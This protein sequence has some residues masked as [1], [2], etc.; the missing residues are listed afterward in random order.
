MQRDFLDPLW[1]F[2]LCFDGKS[3]ATVLPEST[4]GTQAP[5]E[6]NVC[7]VGNFKAA[8]LNKNFTADPQQ[9][10]HTDTQ[11]VRDLRCP[12]PGRTSYHSKPGPVDRLAESSAC[13]WGL[14]STLRVAHSSQS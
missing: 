12:D 5:Y 3:I 1:T 9:R 13:I 11:P 8:R 10:S 6:P 4:G 7:R 2:E 14:G